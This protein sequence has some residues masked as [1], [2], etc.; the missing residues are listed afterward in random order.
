MTSYA[1]VHYFSLLSVSE[2]DHQKAAV[3]YLEKFKHEGCRV[4][5]NRRTQEERDY[6]G[7]RIQTLHLQE[8]QSCQI[9]PLANLPLTGKELT[10]TQA[11]KGIHALDIQ[12]TKILLYNLSHT[13]T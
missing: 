8:C 1:W 12:Y 4:R 10:V 2:L 13:H 9:S 3:E 6:H 11:T 7:M 5:R